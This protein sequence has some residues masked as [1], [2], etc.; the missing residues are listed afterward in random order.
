MLLRATHATVGR[1][2]VSGGER[3]NGR[4]KVTLWESL[5]KELS[6]GTPVFL[7]MVSIELEGPAEQVISAANTFVA[8]LLSEYRRSLS[9]GRVPTFPEEPEA[10]PKPFGS[11][12]ETELN[13]EFQRHLRSQIYAEV[14]PGRNSVSEAWDGVIE[15]DLVEGGTLVD[16]VAI[17]ENTIQVQNAMFVG[18]ASPTLEELVLGSGSATLRIGEDSCE[19]DLFNDEQQQGARRGHTEI[20]AHASS[21]EEYARRLVHEKRDNISASFPLFATQWK[22]G[23]LASDLYAPMQEYSDVEQE[24]ISV[25]ETPLLYWEDSKDIASRLAEASDEQK[26]T[27]NLATALGYPEEAAREFSYDTRNRQLVR[28][29]F[30]LYQGYVQERYDRSSLA[31][32]PLLPYKPASTHDGIETAVTDASRAYETIGEFGESF[33]VD[34]S[35][36]LKNWIRN[37]VEREEAQRGD[38]AVGQLQKEA[39]ES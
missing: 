36:L 21:F 12:I 37:P 4:E 30:L 19:L 38:V 22:P 1:K 11:T 3:V 33:N 18:N 24:N 35:P 17:N 16:G 31:L 14:D 9:S 13:T 10:L 8:K 7:H 20:A 15:L 39:S 29:S 6:R 28:Y 25:I 2:R 34:V 5:T 32:L 26:A 23:L 27:K